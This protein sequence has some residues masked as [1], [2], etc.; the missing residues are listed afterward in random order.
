MLPLISR[1]RSRRR[2]RSGRLVLVVCG[3]I[4]TGLLV[5]GVTQID[6]QSGP[7]NS[8]LNRSFAT[9][10]SVVVDES[11]ATG[12]ELQHVMVTL[13]S[14]HRKTLQTELDSLVRQTSA[15]SARA[16]VI[17]APA[18]ET[19]LQRAFAGVF[20]ERAAATSDLRAAVDGLLGMHP[21]PVVGTAGARTVTSNPVL[22]SANEAAN[23]MA[24]AGD[25][26]LRSDGTFRTVR[27]S[28]AVATGHGHLPAS[29][30]VTHSQQWQIG[31]VATQVDLVVASPTLVAIHQLLLRSVRLTPPGLP[32][33]ATTPAGTVVLS[34][35]ASLTLSVVVANAGTVDEPVATVRFTITPLP[36]GASETQTVTA[37]V[38]SGGYVVM[39]PVT[40]AVLPGHSYQLT[41]SIVPPAAQTD[42]TGTTLTDN[43]Q[44]APGS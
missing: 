37:P 33:S 32:P 6:A 39:A 7:F 12:S 23:R 20:A 16:S 44:V 28:L 34:P 41:I 13:P 19:A 10:G 22:L 42:F 26:L 21:L 36:T 43:L 8:S 11:N 30:W 17:L 5:G 14:E 3:L 38:E 9:L 15:Q 4:V 1:R 29:R 24:A 35:T 18:Q 31:A 40:F 25:L 27:R 2:S